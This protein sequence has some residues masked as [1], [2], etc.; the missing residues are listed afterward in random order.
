MG[1]WIVIRPRDRDHDRAFQ[2]YPLRRPR[3]PSRVCVRHRGRRLARDAVLDRRIGTGR[4]VG[5][6]ALAARDSEIVCRRTTGYADRRGR[7]RGG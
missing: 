6:L 5:A 4:I 2:R 1:P 7:R 3:G